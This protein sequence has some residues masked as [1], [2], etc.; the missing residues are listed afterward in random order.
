MLV[1]AATASWS[2]CGGDDPSLEKVAQPAT[3]DP[4]KSWSWPDSDKSRYLRVC[5]E[6]DAETMDAVH[7]TE[8][9]WVREAAQRSWM[10][11]AWINTWD[12][13]TCPATTGGNTIRVRIFDAAVAKAAKKSTASRSFVGTDCIGKTPA[14]NLNHTFN[15]GWNKGCSSSDANFQHCIKAIAAHEFGHAFGF[16][17]E[18]N[19][20]IND[21]FLCARRR[22]RP[23]RLQGDR[24]L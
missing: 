22:C 15:T 20:P 19:S 7:D 6:N 8:K 16:E 18:Q 21:R 14:M 4:E 5:W 9:V 11:W 10:Q 13:G 12:W 17:H 24:S 1:F 23:N 3:Y 2:G